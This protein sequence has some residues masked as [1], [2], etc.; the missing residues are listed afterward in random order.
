MTIEVVSIVVLAAS[1]ST[2]GLVRGWA[3]RL[4][5]VAMPCTDR[6]NRRPIALLGGIGIF[7]SFV[8]GV[9]ALRPSIPGLW[10][11][12]C[13]ATFLFIVGLVD[14]LHA[15]KPHTKLVMQVVASS[16]LP[17]AGLVLPW[18]PYKIVNDVIT[19]FWMVGITNAVNLLDNMDG[20]AG[21]VAALACLFQTVYFLVNR[22]AA[23]ATIS[24][25]LACAIAGFL[26]FNFSPASIFMGDCGSLFLGFMLGGTA[27]LNNWDRSRGLVAVLLTPVLIML[28]PIVDTSLVTVTRVLRGR[29]VSR[30]GKDHVSHR[31]VATGLSERRAV[32]LLYGLTGV[33]G[34]IA[35]ALRYL[36][37]EVLYF[38]VPC[39][40]LVVL[41]FALHLSMIRVYNEEE[42]PQGSLFPF[43]IDF[44]YKR[45]IL[46][47][48]FDLVLM[49]LA[50]YGA[51]LLRFGGM[52]PGQ[53]LHIFERFAPVVLGVETMVF[54][55]GGLYRGLWRYVGI[56]DVIV[57]VRCVMLAGMASAAVILLM[58]TRPRLSIAVLILD[59]ILLLLLVAGSRVALRLFG[60]W[61]RSQAAEEVAATPVL[62]YGAG[63]RGDLLVRQMLGRGE[64]V[65]VGF[66]DDD[67]GKAGRRLHGISIYRPSDLRQVTGKH[68]VSEVLV[69]SAKIPEEKV[70]ALGIAVRRI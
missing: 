14:D 17:L 35:F 43:L 69:S 48:L 58:Q 19:L 41:F 8:A 37:E 70:R 65:P 44:S 50:Y 9:L 54:L 6:W 55:L 39:F 63:A 5:V 25:L 51:F 20:L 60:A 40:A 4:G 47:V 22:Q 18:T 13:A 56:E 57:I 36:H 62:I 66:L 10:Q 31:L 11:L 28:V 1:V 3:R 45:R 7:I 38:V 49:T 34:G 16:V 12:M 24:L 26:A 23:A 61:L 2:T 21:G 30:G 53:Q 59:S 29:P 15:L 27:L 46:E 64:Y 67:K 42:S 68:V 32:M 52:I 33:S